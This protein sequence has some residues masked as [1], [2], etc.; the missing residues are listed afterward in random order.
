MKDWSEELGAALDSGDP[1]YMK[2]MMARVPPDILQQAT[3]WVEQLAQASLKEDRLQDAL[4]SF[5]HLIALSPDNLD[6]RL[7]RTRICLR[8]E[9]PAEALAEAVRFAA[10]APE[11][12]EGFL[13]E[14]EARERLGENKPALIAYRKALD[15]APGDADL[16]QR[17]QQLETR[18]RKDSILKQTLDPDTAVESVT[19]VMP[20]PEARFDPAM[21]D[22]PSLPEATA[23]FR[24]EGLGQHLSRYGNQQSPRQCIARLEDPEWLKAWDSALS[25]LA[26][27]SVLFCGSELGVFGLR[28]LHHG[29]AQVLCAESYALDA[30]IT[31]GMVQK[32]FLL[33]WQERHGADLKDRTPEERRAS[34]EAFVQGIDIEGPDGNQRDEGGYDVLVFPRIDHSL[35]GT[36]IV[37]AIRRHQASA[38]GKPTRVLP[39]RATLFAMAIQWQYPS[40]D[41][42]LPELDRLRWSL[43]PQA[44][45]LDAT[46]WNALTTPIQVGEIDF[47]DFKEQ[48]L[49]VELPVV[50]AG[51]VDAIVYWFDLDLGVARLGNAPGSELQC[52]KPAVQYTDPIDVQP[53]QSLP[54]RIRIDETR[55]YVQAQPAPKE[56]HARNVPAWFIPTLG[57]QRRYDAYGK[58]LIASRALHPARTALNI[59]AGCGLLATLAVRAGV[60]R[61]VGTETQAAIRAVGRDA[62]KRV[63]LESRIALLDKDCHNLA[64]PEDI[65]ERAD[66]ALFD[67]FDCSLIGEGILHFL[68]HAR[69]HLLDAHARFLPA[70]ARIR[71]MLIEYR[72]DRIMD[73]DANLL[74]PYR[75]SPSFINVDAGTLPYRALSAPFDVFDFDFSTDGPTPAGKELAIRAIAPGTAGGVLF[76]FD[77]RMDPSAWLSNAPHSGDAL[78]WKQGLQFL[79]EVHVTTGMDLPLLARHDGSQLRFQWQ[80]DALPA[81]SFSRLPRF[82]PRWLAASQELEQQ[83]RDLLQHC[84]QNPD[85]FAK[86]SDLAM[87][88][89]IDPAAHGLDPVIAQRFAAMMLGS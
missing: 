7:E 77:L 18:L 17:I 21:L 83:T 58:A 8:L 45:E 16:T 70:G 81:E 80:A 31:A 60:E 89:A 85:E 61:V 48:H 50:R 51:Q 44:L 56:L 53:M 76:W 15:R 78:K 14:G 75:F 82:D 19:E 5:D 11:R 22:D 34:F 74:N 23:P 28:A 57:D 65:D 43:Y 2:A 41:V 13:L 29:A 63:G 62:I 6:A 40:A 86:V 38:A 73:I 79:P 10:L 33:P 72:L 39:A 87:R 9:A 69:E 59:G 52:I 88:F 1:E 25:A 3:V 54:V 27:D 64:V 84:A 20:R 67:A 30:R 49:Q 36:G 4:V 68:A 55:L 35:L 24:V 12:V 47:V 66:L 37:K 26:G 42:P 32:H 71:A 46:F